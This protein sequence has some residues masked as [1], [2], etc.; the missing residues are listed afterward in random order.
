MELMQ[1]I[2]RGQID[3]IAR[4]CAEVKPLVVISCL[5]YNHEKYLRDALEGFVRQK[6]DFPFVAVV[7]DDASTDGTA[8]VLREYAERYP[9][10]ILPIFEDENQY[11]KN[12][13]SLGA[14]MRQARVA[15][16]AKYVAL[17]EGDDYW[18]DPLKLQ[19]QVGF[20]ESHPDYSMC[21]ANAMMHWHDGSQ[22]DT[23]FSEV[24]DKDYRPYD[25]VEYW[26][27]PTASVVY[28]IAVDSDERRLR[29]QRS[30]KMIAGDILLFLTCF[31]YG[32]VRGM[33]DFMSVY[34]RLTTGA[35]IATIDRDPYRYMMHEV[36]LGKA[37]GGNILKFFKHKTANRTVLEL[38]RLKDE[39]TFDV[40]YFFRCFWFAPLE[41]IRQIVRYI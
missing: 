28:R 22:P 19:K 9:D 38:K 17:C 24:T 10:I 35:V 6:T 41:S 12:D 40:K 7:H 4:K 29:L 2:T 13:G 21:F 32:K 39:R 20:L 1:Q 5:T 26:T 14:V 37:F 15:T 23:P 18:T 3:L 16:G 25:F 11:S 31:S 34:R 33:S 8:A 36:T 27:V 30:G